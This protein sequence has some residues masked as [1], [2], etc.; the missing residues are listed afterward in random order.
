MSEVIQMAS[1][2]LNVDESKCLVAVRD[3]KTKQMRQCRN[4]RA[5]GKCC[6]IHATAQDCGDTLTFIK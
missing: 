6:V 2:S 5:D 1:K 3:R 4:N